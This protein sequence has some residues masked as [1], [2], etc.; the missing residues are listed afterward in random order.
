MGGDLVTIDDAAENSW[1]RST[2]YQPWAPWYVAGGACWIGLNDAAQEGQ[3]VWASGSAAPYRNFNAG[4]PNNAD[5]GEDYVWMYT[6]NG[7]WND[8]QATASV[9]GVVEMPF[10]RPIAVATTATSLSS[11]TARFNGAVNAGGQST[12]VSFRYGPSPASLINSVAASPAT[13][14]GTSMEGITATVSVLS[15]KQTVYWRI[16]AYNPVWG[17]NYSDI[18]TFTHLGPGSIDPVFSTDGNQTTPFP[19]GDAEGECAAVQIDGKIVVAGRAHNGSNRDIALARYNTD[20]SLDNSFGS[21]GKVIT[22]I[23]PGDERAFGIALQADGKIV[24]TGFSD[25]ASNGGDV[26]V[27]RYNSNGGLDGSFGGG[28]GIVTTTVS[29]SGDAGYDVAVLPDGKILVAGYGFN[30]NYDDFVLLRYLSD[31]SPDSGFGTGGRWTIPVGTGSSAGYDMAVQPDGKIVISGYSSNG[32]NYDFTVLRR[33]PDGSPDTGFNGTGQVAIPMGSGPDEATG[34]AVMPNGKIV[35]VGNSLGPVNLDFAVARFNP[36]GSLDTT[37]SDDGKATFD[38][39]GGTQ[40]AQDVKVLPDGRI[41]LAGYSTTNGVSDFAV[42][43]ITAAGTLDTSFGNGGYAILPI[44]A[45]ND[46]AKDI[47]LQA[48]GKIV[49][50][51]H[52]FT[53]TKNEFAVARLHGPDS[54]PPVPRSFTMR[55]TPP[56]QETPVFSVAE[57]VTE[58]D[59]DPV[60]LSIVGHTVPGT[61]TTDGSTVRVTLSSALTADVKITVRA[62]DSHGSYQDAVIV[63]TA[64][65]PGTVD[66]TFDGDGSGTG[67]PAGY[68]MLSFPGVNAVV[69]D[70]KVQPDG[71]VVAVGYKGTDAIVA[72]FHPNGTVDIGFGTNGST[73]IPSG[74]SAVFRRMALQPDGKIVAV[75]YS[76]VSGNGRY[77]VARFTTSGV[78]DGTFDA[79]GVKI[80]EVGPS[81]DIGTDVAIQPDGKIVLSGYSYTGSAYSQSAVRLLPDGAYD[82]SFDTDGKVTVPYAENSL[83]DAVAVMADGKIVLA[84]HTNVGGSSDFCAA[85]LTSTGA[86]DTTFG[87]GGKRIVSLSP[88]N[89]FCE[90]M[91]VQPDGKLLLG[92]RIAGPVDDPPKDIALLRLDGEGVPDGSFGTDG[93]LVFAASPSFDTCW[94]LAVQPDGKIVAA[95]IIAGSFEDMAVVRFHADGTPDDSF[96]GD[97]ILY[98]APGNLDDGLLAV[99]VEA[100][101]DIFGGGYSDDT[102]GVQRM[103]VVKLN[104][105]GAEPDIAVEH[106]VNTPLTDGG[107]VIDCG[108]LSIGQQVS[109]TFTIRNTGFQTLHLT[110]SV[111]VSVPGSF[112]DNGMSFTSLAP[113]ASGEYTFTFQAQVAGVHS[114]TLSFVSNDPDES[115]FDITLTCEVTAPEIA[116]FDG[117]AELLD[118][119]AQVVDLGETL[120]G[121]NMVHTLTIHN[122]GNAPLTLST[123]QL[124]AGLEIQTGMPALPVTIVAGTAIN[125]GIF[126]GTQIGT[127]Q[128]AVEISCDDPDEAVFNFPVSAVVRGIPEIALEHPAGVDLPHGSGLQFGTLAAGR[129]T[130]AKTVTIKNTGNGPLAISSISITGANPTEFPM[131]APA[132]PLEIA[133]GGQETLTITFSP[134]GTTTGGRSA[135]LGITC[136]DPDE[137]T[138]SRLLEGLG[139]S[140]VDDNDGDGMS[141]WAEH[142][143]AGVG[144]DWTMNQTAM[145]TALYGGANDA[146]LYTP[147]QVQALH[148]GTPLI[149]RNPDTGK[150]KLTM[151]WKKSTNLADFFDFPAPVS[152]VSVNP[153]GD[154]ELEFTSPDDA[155]FFRVE[156]R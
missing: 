78:P 129:G 135:T 102:S 61:V 115:P 114:A 103:A 83:A 71:K 12:Q 57:D 121:N 92:G 76:I 119:Q 93:K 28:D 38:P 87:L 16:Q 43:G 156:A 27:L 56:G 89:D 134:A 126:F 141:D 70:V 29:S 11:G 62:T 130:A 4:E 18:Q 146:G 30:G 118:G 79:E 15:A 55:A 122:Q 125:F 64:R 8:E 22:P 3:F 138:L 75:G 152:G 82:S 45:G 77:L 105:F 5:G 131:T 86:L 26:A 111:S 72:R 99:E 19:S 123:I 100:D 127:F 151:D 31:G 132:V 68:G 48:D 32:T 91:T 35:A 144:F 66:P 10:P 97:G 90:G 88:G 49:V 50:A 85:R 116:V 80:V 36:D 63:L 139:L 96:A 140:A 69:R 24:V 128:G 14:S 145:V 34:V 41:L 142:R 147:T 21:A 154:I 33:H 9:P 108:V 148:V 133:P 46:V 53:G 40:G 143:L 17:T 37:F 112:I 107:A 74:T 52:A 51:G 42:V 13:V 94:D 124:P 58:P 54:L 136:D 104:G 39:N 25:T 109:K 120:I 23:G 149:S 20:G 47:S 7:T 113:G 117:A 73:V 106:P 110:T 67:I 60:T 137:G 98:L 84:G 44:G 65:S 101:G 1:V 81:A 155:A 6:S 150:F 59:G 2:F 95:G 153:Q